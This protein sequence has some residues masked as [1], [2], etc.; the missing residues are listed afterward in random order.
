MYNLY[1]LETLGTFKWPV[2]IFFSSLCTFQ[3][4]PLHRFFCEIREI[5]DVDVK[6]KFSLQV[7][8][9]TIFCAVT[10]SR[11]LILRK[12]AIVSK[13]CIWSIK[14]SL[15]DKACIWWKLLEGEQKLS[16]RN[17]NALKYWRSF[18]GIYFIFIIRFQTLK[19]DWRPLCRDATFYALSIGA[20][21]GF[22][23]DGKFELWESF[24][25]LGLYIAYIIMMKFNR[26]LMA[27][28]DKCW[29]VWMI[30]NFSFQYR[31]FSP[32][33]EWQSVK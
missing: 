19:L 3:N 11:N 6:T 14:F 13:T 17:N 25:M 28:L 33:H 21:I 26:N 12:G 29:W 31:K 30:T 20:F 24:V 9:S 4:S 16:F 22:S 23:W 2:E 5:R 1:H 8:N 10:N 15:R 32:A 7:D 27:L 18:V